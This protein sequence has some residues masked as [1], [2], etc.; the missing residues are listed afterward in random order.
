[1]APSEDPDREEALIV[2]GLSFDGRANLATIPIERNEQDFIELKDP[3]L[4]PITPGLDAQMTLIEKFYAGF[5]N[6]LRKQMDSVNE[7]DD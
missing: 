7:L 1:M 6:E 3:D 2:A 5:K 4:M